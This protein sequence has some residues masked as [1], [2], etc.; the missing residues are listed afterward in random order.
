LIYQVAWTRAL[1][2]VTSATTIVQSLILAVFM[3]GLGAGAIAAGRAC[4]RLSSPLRAYA[5]V[6]LLA[7]TLST[8][9]FPLVTTS[10]Y[11][12][13]FFFNNLG[14]PLE[15]GLYMQLAIISLYLFIP[16]TLLGASLPLLIEHFER[17]RKMDTSKRGKFLGSIYGINTAG[18]IGGSYLAGFI[19][20]PELGLT[21]TGTTGAALALVAIAIALVTSAKQGGTPAPRAEKT[22]ATNNTEYGLLGAAFLAG[23]VGLAAEILWLRI[24]AL[25]IPNTVYTFTEV[26]MAVLTGISLGSIGASLA[27]RLSARQEKPRAHLKKIA[28]LCAL[29]A[30]IMIGLIPLVIMNVATFI[31]L[32]NAMASGQSFIAA[33][34]LLAC[35]V[36]AAAL[37]GAILPLVATASE[38]PD[39]SRAFSTV[40]GANT[41]GALLGSLVAGLIL[42]PIVG[43]RNASLVVQLACLVLAI[44]LLKKFARTWQSIAI[45]GVAIFATGALYLSADIPL[46]IY[47]RRIS[48]NLVIR[49]FHEG[50]SSHV[51]VTE[52][53][54]TH[55]RKL[56][57]NS[58]W[59]ASDGGP[60][61]AFGHLPALFAESPRRALGIALGTGQTFAAVLDHGVEQLDCVE[62]DSGVIKLARRWFSDV[63]DGLLDDHRAKIHLNDGRAFLRIAA[64]DTYNI[65]VLE[66]LQAWTA[67]TSSLYSKEFYLE[68]KKSLA[69]GGVLSQWIPFYGQGVAET[70]AMINT[71]LSVFDHGSLWLAE[72][73]G[74]LLLSDSPLILSLDQLQSRIDQRQ[75]VRK[76]KRFP[77]TSAADLI[78]FLMLGNQGLRSW[79]HNAGLIEDNY[80]FLEFQAANQ[81]GTGHRRFV[82]ILADME[83]HMDSVLGYVKNPTGP[84]IAEYQAAQ[85]MRSAAIRVKLMSEDS[86]Q[87]R[88]Q[89]LKSLPVALRRYSTWQNL[90]KRLK[91]EIDKQAHEERNENQSN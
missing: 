70:K 28:G 36:P 51:M 44:I 6:E 67:G 12:P 57:I 34:L 91:Q 55:L 23:F 11:I 45:Y 14:I 60:H 53:T 5:F 26:I 72:K 42:I 22:T 39:G 9:A 24:F 76:L 19:T 69:P 81:I 77:A 3:A 47:K 27:T 32:Q 71:G 38:I 48:K 37:I 66:P 87:D 78:T 33:V 79:V 85:S 17:G 89:F 80:P 31:P 20:I 52:D 65:I 84:E 10:Q 46:D 64:P 56:W 54:R 40:Y 43:L 75:K 8:A 2:S 7:A 49:E 29:L 68:A 15:S 61:R 30:M 86:P 50:T 13:G 83:P 41:A 59:V 25:V 35:V 62:I 82:E 74:I 63:N 16:A 4:H 90:T 73:D 88:L 18:A 58:F 21:L 1:V